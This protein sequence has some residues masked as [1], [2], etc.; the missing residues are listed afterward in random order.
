M[1]NTCSDNAIVADI[2]SN[3]SHVSDQ[4]S[5]TTPDRSWGL[6]LKCQIAQ[7]NRIQL[8]HKKRL[9]ERVKTHCIASMYGS[10][11]TTRG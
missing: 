1:R 8:G 3:N 9:A 11:A 4:S 10:K 5:Y 6:G 7:L 2:A